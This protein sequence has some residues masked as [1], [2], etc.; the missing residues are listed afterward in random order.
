MHT[1]MK[2]D[3]TKTECLEK[4]MVHPGFFR[5]FCTI[6]LII[7]TAWFGKTLNTWRKFYRLTNS[8]QGETTI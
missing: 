6:P 5:V 7:F 4:L 3:G 8:K 2:H 1:I